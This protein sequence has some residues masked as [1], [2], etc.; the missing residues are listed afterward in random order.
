MK[1]GRNRMRTRRFARQTGAALIIS[2]VILLAMTLIGVSSMDSAVLELKMAAT[3]QQQIVALNRAEATLID[4][5]ET[6]DAIVADPSPYNFETP[7]DGFYPAVNALDLEHANWDGV[8]TEAG[9][10]HTDNG[11]DDDDQYVIEYL[12]RM[13]IPGESVRMDPNGVIAGGMVYTFRNTTRSS[14]GRD[15][16]RIVQSIYV[17]LDAP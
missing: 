4:A 15:V 14:S 9:P 17:T 8:A 1:N 11:L 2:L 16:V 13:P 12:G 10:E 7:D 6:I 3:M 5:E